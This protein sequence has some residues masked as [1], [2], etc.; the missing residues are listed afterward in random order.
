MLVLYSLRHKRLRQILR[1][2]GGT[3]TP[4]HDYLHLMAQNLPNKFPSSLSRPLGDHVVLDASGCRASV[5]IERDPN[6]SQTVLLRA[7]FAIPKDLFTYYFEIKVVKR[8]RLGKITLGFVPSAA[9]QNSQPGYALHEV[10]VV[11]A[12]ISVFRMRIVLDA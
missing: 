3:W 11:P 12:A 4:Y 6:S 2:A 8:G 1:D 5:P 9:K 7:N 10:S